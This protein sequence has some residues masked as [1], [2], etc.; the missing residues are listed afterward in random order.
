MEELEAMNRVYSYLFYAAGV[1][2]LIVGAF[3]SNVYLILFTSLLLLLS[4]VYLNSGHILNNLFIRRSGIIE[5]YNGYRLNEN[6]ESAVKKLGERYVSRSVSLLR[7]GKDTAAGPD[8]IGRLIESIHEPFE[9]SILL[10]EADRKRILE[11][12]ETKRRM[13]EIALSRLDQKKQD[14]V[15]AVRREIDIVSTELENIRKGGKALEVVMKLCA[16]AE[17]ENEAQAARESSSGIRHVSDAF[18]ASLG[19][20]YRILRGEELLGFFEAHS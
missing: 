4:A 10:E 9:Y 14:S 2:C 12:L 5:V 19:L 3:F 16:S 7:P 13:K 11:G 8:T 15:N 1:L 18:S 20:D 17:S 6:L